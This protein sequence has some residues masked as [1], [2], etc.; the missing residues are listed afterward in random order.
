MKTETNEFSFVLKTSLIPDAGIG[1]FAAHDIA[2]GTMLKLFSE[3]MSYETATRK[4]KTEVVPEAFKIY[5][6]FREDGFLDCPH[7]FSK[8]EIGWHLNHGKKFN[9]E[10]KDY[11]YYATQDI[12][13]G[14]EIIIDY[15]TLDEP[16]DLK[17]EYYAD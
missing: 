7:D 12:I 5:C 16:E 13:A 17:E 6:I 15:N 14:E 9:A 3:E 4:L 1:V 10:H 11:I 2:K 8:M